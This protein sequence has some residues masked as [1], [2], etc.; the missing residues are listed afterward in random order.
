MYLRKTTIQNRSGLH[1]RPAAD[2]VAMATKYKSKINIKK[3]G[4][5][6]DRNAK[7]I[8]ML[9]SL[10]LTCGT[11]V[12]IIATGEDETEAVNALVALIESRFNE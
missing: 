10:G 1:A 4:S 9:L 3:A 7:S 8:I 5:D 12:E 6:E 2:F 11:E